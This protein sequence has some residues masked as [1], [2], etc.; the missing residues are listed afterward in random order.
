MTYTTRAAVDLSSHPVRNQ[1]ITGSMTASAGVATCAFTASLAA[2]PVYDAP[3][4]PT[5]VASNSV[6]PGEAV[7]S[8]D[9]SATDGTVAMVVGYPAGAI[10]GPVAIGTGGPK[11]GPVAL[12]AASCGGTDANR[13]EVGTGPVDRAGAVA[14][15]LEEGIAV[16]SDAGSELRVAV[17]ADA[18]D[19]GVKVRIR[20]A[21][22]TSAG[23]WICPSLICVTGYKMVSYVASVEDA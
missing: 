15:T 17:C 19:S 23:A 2:G 10:G 8:P 6:S 14:V 3:A 1:H 22:A 4:L 20:E 7:V 12:R 13:M 21:V 9:V 5:L 16:I 18:A 11:V